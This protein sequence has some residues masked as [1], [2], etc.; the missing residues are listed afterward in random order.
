MKIRSSFNRNLLGSIIRRRPYVPSRLPQLIAVV[1]SAVG[2]ALLWPPSAIISAA[3]A[4]SASQ[5]EAGKMMHDSHY[6]QSC[7]SADCH[8]TSKAPRYIKHPPFLEQQCLTCHRDHSVSSNDLLTNRGDAVCLACHDSVELAPDGGALSH[9]QEVGSCLEC[10]NPHQSR[11]PHLLR[12][13]SQKGICA[14]CHESFLQEADSRKFRHHFFDPRSQCGDCHYAHKASEKKY[15]REDVGETCLTCHDLPIATEGRHLEN[16]AEQLR[17]AP[18]VHEALSEPES[19]SLCHTPHG[20]DQSALLKDG[21]P[22]LNYATY[23]KERYALCWQCHS[24]DLAEKANGLGI[25]LFRDG[26]ANLHQ[27]HVSKLSQGRA[28]HLC[29]AAH[30]SNSPSLIRSSFR[31]GAWDAPLVFKGDDNGGNC[32]T[33]CHRP[34]EYR[35]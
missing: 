17:D 31:F 25:T 15:L 28:C 26:D 6:N 33:P 22:S 4:P 30:A 23:E 14:D 35:R 8:P 19:C 18:S 9:P 29:H 27:T 10:H 21:Y 13:E 24:S 34:K 12:D 32:L 16:V 20:S 3:V 2:L 7:D 1:A 11:I 5:A